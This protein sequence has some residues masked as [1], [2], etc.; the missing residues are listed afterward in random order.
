MKTLLAVLLLAMLGP[1]R[2]GQY[3]D[4]WWNPQ[5]S[6]WGLNLVQQQE[7]AF[8]TL[9]V[10][11]ADGRPTWY[12][13]PA[14]RITHFG[15][16]GPIFAGTFY[17]ARGP[18]HGGRFDP[19]AVQTA[20]VG[21]LSLEV[22][23]KDRMRVYYTAEDGVAVVKDVVRMTW[24]QPL[25][26]A[27][28]AG[29]FALRQVPAAGGPPA[30]M[31]DYPGD[32]LV[33]FDPDTGQG[34]MRVDDPLRRCEYR[35]PYQTTGK[36]IRFSGNYTCTTGDAA[37]GTFEVNDLEVTA[38]GISGYLRTSASDIHQFGRFAAVLR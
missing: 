36:L 15:S 32:V 9:F 13:A 23:A 20:P 8:V 17:R 30:G 5:E 22:L 4:L 34:F 3:S 1:A 18:W 11:D 19:G 14:A 28:Y 2:A 31:R 29:Q 26:G 35:G 25:I 10:Y 6:G 21:E 16:T 12:F 38:N 33:H 37:Q 24:D 7:T 27:F